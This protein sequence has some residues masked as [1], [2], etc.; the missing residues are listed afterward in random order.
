MRGSATPLDVIKNEMNKFEKFYSFAIEYPG[1]MF[2]ILFGIG[3][4]VFIN[5]VF[6]FSDMKIEG[7]EIDRSDPLIILQYFGIS[8]F[9]PIF[10]A[11][12]ILCQKHVRNTLFQNEHQDKT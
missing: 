7:E 9:G 2:A 6:L 8:L 4:F 5:Y 10:S 12:F 11:L 3:T 1:R